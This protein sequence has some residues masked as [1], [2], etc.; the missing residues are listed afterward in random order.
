[1][2][3]SSR[4]RL[5]KLAPLLRKAALSTLLVAVRRTVL[6]FP[7]SI[8]RARAVI[9]IWRHAM[10]RTETPA[11]RRHRLLPPAI[12]PCVQQRLVKCGIAAAELRSLQDRSSHAHR[13]AWR[14][15]TPLPSPARLGTEGSL[16]LPLVVVPQR[17][18]AR[19]RGTR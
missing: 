12:L 15:P 1:M 18:H 2:G 17:L 5:Q 11:L 8:H 13:D 9:R 4:Q 14:L 3:A 16:A 10:Q 19:A 7:R 6:L